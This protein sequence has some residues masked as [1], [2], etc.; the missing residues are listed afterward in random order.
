MPLIEDGLGNKEFN[1]RHK[2]WDKYDFAY[3]ISSAYK[4]CKPIHL[5]DLKSCYGSKGA[6]RGLVYVPD[7]ISKDVSGMPRSLSYA[8]ASSSEAELSRSR[9][10]VAEA[11]SAVATT[12]RGLGGWSLKLFVGYHH[13]YN[14]L[15]YSMYRLS[16]RCNIHT[17][18]EASL[19]SNTVSPRLQR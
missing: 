5:K 10:S 17:R 19:Q 11:A 12:P 16:C 3:R 1:E 15:L 7:T 4:N 6:P 18:S 8:W 2:N 13:E 14:L 9:I